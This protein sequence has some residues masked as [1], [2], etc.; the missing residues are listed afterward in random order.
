MGN[1]IPTSRTTKSQSFNAKSSSNS[2]KRINSFPIP[3]TKTSFKS[4]N[5]FKDNNTMSTTTTTTAT[6]ASIA[7][8]ASKI[9]DK[10]EIAFINEAIHNQPLFRKV[11]GEYIKTVLTKQFMKI[12]VKAGVTLFNEHSDINYAFLIYKGTLTIQQRNNNNN[13]SNSNT[14]KSSGEWLFINEIASLITS[15]DYNIINDNNSGECIVFSL[16]ADAISDTIAYVRKKN[17]EHFNAFVNQY[18]PNLNPYD[19]IRKNIISECFT[20]YK[21]NTNEYINYGDN[22][23]LIYS[24]VVGELHSG[25]ESKN[26]RKGDIIGH[27]ELI[28]QQ[29]NPFATT[30][31]DISLKAKEQ[32]EIIAIPYKKLPRYLPKDAL[33]N[34]I[35]YFMLSLC[36]TTS[37]TVSAIDDSTI[38]KIFPLFNFHFYKTNETIYEK[39][40]CLNEVVIAII[41]GNIFKKKSDRYEGIR[42]SLLYEKELISNEHSVLVLEDLL[43][44]PDC[45]IMSADM[46]QIKSVLKGQSIRDLLSKNYKKKACQFILEDLMKRCGCYSSLNKQ[47]LSEIEKYISIEKYDNKVTILSQGDKNIDKFYIIKS[48]YV[49][50]YVNNMFIRNLGP[51]SPFGFKAF[52]NGNNARTATVISLDHVEL[53]AIAMKQFNMLFMSETNSPVMNYFKH[54][55]L[56]EDN[57][58]T[59]NDLEN[60]R[61]LG[62]GS[63]GFVN[64]V[65]HKKTKFL[66]AIKAIPLIKVI[67]S[68]LY[69]VITNERNVVRVI[70]H[71][72]LMKNVISLKNNEY[73]FIINEYIK[74]KVL[75]QIIKDNNVFPKS[76]SQFYIASL[77]LAVA[78]MHS[79]H[80][81]HRDIK[82]ENIML[83]TDGYVKLID[84]GT[85]KETSTRE[86]TT[87][88]IIGT[89]YYM[90]PEVVKGNSYT[91]AIDYWSIGVCLYEFTFGK[92]PFGAEYKDPLE[93][94]KK[95]LNNDNV[96]YPSGY[97]VKENNDVVSLINSMLNKKKEKRLY[98]KDVMSHIFFEGFNW[99]ALETLTMQAPI[100][101]SR[102]DYDDINDKP[103]N[104]LNVLKTQMSNENVDKGNKELMSFDYERGQKWLKEF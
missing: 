14:N 75:S 54:R 59:L 104:Y 81:I 5:K 64:L 92:V 15:Y 26:L 47:K 44:Y 63:F 9:N 102:S 78:C 38:A 74:G 46:N 73:V 93:I 84:Y 28:L 85:V 2:S 58:I 56:L 70:D 12:N 34:C 82:P 88:T 99:N 32:T 66:Y 53:F 3:S 72:F 22:L 11:D 69:E 43:A 68:E 1:N 4:Q 60:I 10:N 49:G 29:H 103:T 89:P 76:Q 87:N 71:N 27:S 51:S 13:S 20:L 83:C 31:N 97:N 35:A 48:G 65:R 52:L 39:G 41:E 61:L 45:L 42:C 91:Y 100:K 17:K 77:L 16:H 95:I 19:L 57:T 80:F 23:Y 79:N 21:Y 30:S 7:K 40:E 36:F 25:E 24:G 6:T 86:G 50:I 37:E 18:Y 8:S 62:K 96:S 67:Y 101:L 94:Y 55:N 90:A 33:G 98:G